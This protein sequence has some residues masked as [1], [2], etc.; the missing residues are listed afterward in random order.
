MRLDRF[1]KTLR[2]LFMSFANP[3]STLKAYVSQNYA[4]ETVCN[5]K[6]WPLPKLKT[7]P[8]QMG[9]SNFE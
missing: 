5:K 8:H 6:Q 3:L 4:P 7:Q 9:Y 2:R 1:H